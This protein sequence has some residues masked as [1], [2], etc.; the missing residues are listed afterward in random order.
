MLEWRDRGFPRGWGSSGGGG[1]W[2]AERARQQ[3]H[4]ARLTAPRRRP[5]PL[6]PPHTRAPQALGAIDSNNQIS[7]WIGVVVMLLAVAMNMSAVD[8]L[9]NG[10]TAG[11]SSH[12]LKGQHVRWTKLAVFLLNVPLIVLGARPNGLD[13]KARWACRRAG[14]GLCAQGAPPRAYAHA[15]PPTPCSKL[16]ACQLLCCPPLPPPSTLIVLSRRCW[17]SSCWPT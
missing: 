15:P 16:C 2:E 3:A 14:P 4:R 5:A 1:W 8:S 12:L 11:V 10:L 13:L 7:K 6:P 9:Q 17:T